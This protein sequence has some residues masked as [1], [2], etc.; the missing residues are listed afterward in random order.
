MDQGRCHRAYI[1]RLTAD[2]ALN[3][4]LAAG[5]IHP[6]LR[7]AYTSV[8]EAITEQIN[9]SEER[10]AQPKAVKPPKPTKPPSVLDH[11]WEP[12]HFTVVELSTISAKKRARL[13]A[14]GCRRCTRCGVASNTEYPYQFKA[15]GKPWVQVKVACRA[16]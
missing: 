13:E 5:S 14:S 10:A 9:S 1:A 8:A 6:T 7:A 2:R 3:E 4:A 16:P 11:T 15:A 12:S